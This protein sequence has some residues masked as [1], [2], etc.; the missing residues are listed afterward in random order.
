MRGN[1]SDDALRALLSHLDVW[2]RRG[3][4]RPLRPY[5]REAAAAI[6]ASIR[7]GH[8][9]V[10]TVMMSRQAGKNELSAQ[11]ESFLLGRT[12]P[13]FTASG[14]GRA[15]ASCPKAS[16]SRGRPSLPTAAC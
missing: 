10:V 9:D 12:I 2:S 6:L 7:Q 11:L 5:Q 16:P 15:S 13:R 8:G 3:L 14:S 1:R 4:G